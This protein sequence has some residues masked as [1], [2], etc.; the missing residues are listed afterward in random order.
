M[1]SELCKTEQEV[2]LVDAR[3]GAED[4]ED[5]GEERLALVA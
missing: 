5:A 1:S 4:A 3:E 2:D